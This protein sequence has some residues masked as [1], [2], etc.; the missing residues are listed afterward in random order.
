[1]P[2]NRKHIVPMKRSLLALALFL[3]STGSFA[4]TYLDSTIN[5]ATKKIIFSDGFNMGSYGEA[6]YNQEFVEGTFQNGK[7]DLHRLILFMGYKFNEKLSFFTEIEFEHVNEL[8]VEQAYVNYA[9][10]SWA[11]FKAGVLI[12]P[13]GYVNEFHEPTLFNGVERSSVDKYIIPS[14]WREMGFGFHGILKPVNLKY[15][16]YMINGFSGYNGAARISGSSGL[17]SSRQ[18]ASNAIMRKPAVVG[19]MTFYGLNGLRLGIS[20]YHGTSESSLYDGLDRN[21]AAAIATADSSTVGI[22]M[23]AF[24]AHYNWKNI[25]LMAVGNI[26][27]L[28]NADAYNE[29]TGSNVGTQIMGYYGEVAYHIGLK[30][31]QEYPK[32]IPFVR[33]ENYNTHHAVGRDMTANEAYHREILTG[34]ISLQP[35][36]GTTFKA[37][38]QFIKNVA[39]PK[40][41]GML[42]IGFGYW[43]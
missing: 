39:N 22:S 33:Y 2:T 25:H 8:A 40:P 20:G 27:S 34:G 36:P 35:T 43:F 31:E 7:A 19:K 37:D 12:M 1:M 29:F 3:L 38:Y 41:T 11:N 17:R 6:H 13:M 24:N 16:L 21:N 23:A 10:K 4:Q 42:N 26:T 32:L 28:S 18:S 15:Q 14:T 30:S 5:S 9:F